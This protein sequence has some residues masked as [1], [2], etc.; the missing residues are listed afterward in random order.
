M[1]SRLS[2]NL[3][4]QVEKGVSILR[5]GGVIA[6]PTDTVYGLG[7]GIGFPRAIERIYAVKER[8]LSMPLPLLLDDVF[9][10]TEL[11]DSVPPLARLLMEKFWPGGLTLV[12]PASSSVPDFIT[13]G[14]KTVAVRIPD[15]P[16]P[17]ALIKALGTPI[18]GTSANLSGQPSA[19]T[20]DEVYSQIG[21][22]IDFVID[23]GRC[24]G[25]KE[26]TIID[27]TGET[28][29]ILREGAIT[30]AEIERVCGSIK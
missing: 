4:E 2:L 15:H 22:K 3:Q 21:A 10:L 18:V 16:V 14:G 19:L 28:P 12:L 13:A 30:R 23:G 5:N 24:P 20:A 25:G 9:Q 11:A 26:S 1:A 8:P 29:V 17:L 27:V 7:A 6:Y